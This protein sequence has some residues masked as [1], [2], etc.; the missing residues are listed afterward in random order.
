MTNRE[1]RTCATG[2]YQP[3]AERGPGSVAEYL[4][5]LSCIAL[6]SPAPDAISCSRCCWTM[7][8][9]NASVSDGVNLARVCP[10]RLF[11][12][13]RRIK[14]AALRAPAASQPIKAASSSYVSQICG[15]QGTPVIE[16]ACWRD[17]LT[18]CLR[19]VTIKISNLSITGR[20][21]L[22]PTLDHGGRVYDF[23]GFKCVGLNRIS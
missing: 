10:S 3:T 17:F 14:A 7:P 19:Q 8:C 20:P 12:R 11:R 16:E 22:R 4:A 6:R 18:I 15:T 1:L 9:R 5:I 2:E 21:G 23:G 13:S